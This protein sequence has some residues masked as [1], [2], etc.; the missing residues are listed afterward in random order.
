MKGRAH[1]PNV[2]RLKSSNP[3]CYA[4]GQV[5]GSAYCTI[6]PTIASIL[7]PDSYIIPQKGTRFTENSKITPEEIHNV[8]QGCIPS[9][10][11]DPDYQS[12]GK[13]IARAIPTA[14]TSFHFI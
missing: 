1:C 9:T 5:K 14:I 11:L 12:D 6:P 7:T 13:E 10:D 4:K 3:L 8:V 2:G